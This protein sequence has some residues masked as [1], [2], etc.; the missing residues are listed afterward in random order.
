[1]YSFI[2]TILKKRMIDKAIRTQ[3]FSEYARKEKDRDLA[4]TMNPNN[5]KKEVSDNN[6]I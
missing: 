6:I 2:K 5:L 1:M 4:N 3:G